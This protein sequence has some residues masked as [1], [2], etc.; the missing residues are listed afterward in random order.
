MLII[1]GTI[2]SLLALYFFKLTVNVIK[3]RQSLKVS[4]GTGGHESLDRAIRAHGNFSEYVPLALILMACLELN[5]APSVPIWI[6]G[7]V[8]ILSRV[9]HAVG[10]SSAT[11]KVPKR[12]TA[13]VMTFCTLLG[14]AL[15]NLG[16]LLRSV[17]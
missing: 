7:F 5:H 16:W 4:L 13:M 1:T 8:L 17:L 15:F 9:L 3:L 10:I 11:G 14:L 2:A 6:F 12:V